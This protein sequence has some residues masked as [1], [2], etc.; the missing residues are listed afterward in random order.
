MFWRKKKMP[1]PEGPSNLHGLAR[2]LGIERRTTIRIRYPVYSQ[3]CRLPTLSFGKR[4]LVIQDI[5]V[6]GCCVLDS[7][8]ILGPAIG[9][10]VMLEF[11][12]SG[13]IE[14]VTCRIVSRIHHRRHIQFLDL[15]EHRRLLLNASMES[16]VL[17][18]ALRKNSPTDDVAIPVDAVEF[19]SSTSGN[20]IIIENQ[21]HCL[22]KIHFKGE[23]FEVYR[24]A[25]PIRANGESCTPEEIEQLILMTC[26]V[27]SPSPSILDLLLSL[28][29][30]L[31]RG[32]R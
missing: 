29:Q 32:S 18:L 20:N 25:D 31:K 2:R 6:G 9:N 5:S 16:G 17:G 1:P 24:G 13:A 30:R 7:E 23:M 15:P 26:N 14:P 8:Q 12:W 21:V 3:V 27:P 22:A 19:W 4:H 28:E 11:N 10:E